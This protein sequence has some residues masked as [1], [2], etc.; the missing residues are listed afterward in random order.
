[1]KSI[2]S[3]EY[4]SPFTDEDERLYFSFLNE[5]SKKEPFLYSNSWPFI[6]QIARY[7]SKRYYDGKSLITIIGK[8]YNPNYF[9]I[10]KPLGLDPIKKVIFLC[11]VLNKIS[12]RPI[13]IRK[14][15]KEQFMILKKK[16]YKEPSWQTNLLEKLPDDV[17]PQ[18]IC[19]IEYILSLKGKKYS[20]LRQ[21]LNYFKKLNSKAQ[22]FCEQLKK[23]ALCV[24]DKWKASFVSRFKNRRYKLPINN[25]YYFDPYL[26]FI[27][28][29]AKRI[30]NEN[31]FSIIVYINSNPVAFSFYGKISSF[32][33]SQYANLADTRFKGLSEYLTYETLK[34]AH[35]QGFKYVNLGGSETETLHRYNMKFGPFK[36]IKEYYII[37]E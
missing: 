25:S 7:N 24:L 33:I 5:I 29:F 36:F 28:K 6:C 32:C 27:E 14:L 19:N 21:R 30:D 11:K 15:T 13:L 31:Y 12:S 18:P 26:I 35:S 4:I 22:I 2:N 10:V 8:K 20:A 17:Y 9:E 34:I 16:G 1:M 37:Y 23:D 3:L